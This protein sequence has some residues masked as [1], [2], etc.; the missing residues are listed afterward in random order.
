MSALITML[1]SNLI[2]E[3]DPLVRVLVAVAREF[4]AGLACQR[5]CFPELCHVQEIRERVFDLRYV[6]GEWCA[7]EYVGHV[8]RLNVLW[9]FEFHLYQLLNA[10][11]QPLKLF[12]ILLQSLLQP[13]QYCNDSTMIHYVHFDTSFQLSLKRFQIWAVTAQVTLK[14]M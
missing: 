8:F 5:G 14:L 9:W 7:P 1:Q 3:T 6:D 10:V 12:G 13:V 2:A 4:V 11:K